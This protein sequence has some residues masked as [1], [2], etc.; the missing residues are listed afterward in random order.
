VI[1]NGKVVETGTP[2]E[3]LVRGTALAG[4]FSFDRRKEGDPSESVGSASPMTLI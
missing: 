1:D 3:L 2:A 4:L